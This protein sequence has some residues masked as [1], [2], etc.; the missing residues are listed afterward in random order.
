MN[1]LLLFV[2]FGGLAIATVVALMMIRMAMRQSH[3][4]H[5]E[6]EKAEIQGKLSLLE[7]EAAEARSQRAENAAMLEQKT[8]AI[9]E[10]QET[11]RRLEMALAERQQ[12][13]QQKDIAQAGEAKARQELA[14]MQQKLAESEKRMQDW[15]L[16]RTEA[17]SA[18][19]AS[20]LE[21]GGQLS[22]KLLEDHKRER[23]AAQKEAE[24]NAKKH[25]ETLLEQV[26]NLTKSV[27]TI[28][29][30][31][32]QT[33]EK[34]ATVWRALTTPAAAGSLAEVGL[35]NS[36]KNLGLEPV[37]DYMIQY[38]VAG[39]DQSRLRPDAVV[40]LPQDM[41]MVIDSK[42]SKFVLEIAETEVQGKDN[43]EALQKLSKTMNDHLKALVSKDYREAIRSTYRDS[44][45]IGELSVCLSVMYVPSESA[46]THIRNADPAFIERAEKNNIIV[47]SPASLHGLL[48]LARYNIGLQRQSENQEVLI[49]QV[50]GLIDSVITMLSYAE[51][52]GK[53]IKSAADNF[54]KFTRSANKNVF[55][56]MRKLTTLGIRP[57]KGKEL[58]KPL[59]GFEVRTQ[60]DLL[61]IE[62]EVETVQD[63]DTANL[64]DQKL[65]A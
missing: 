50:Q 55:S 7:K 22:S 49:S 64:L 48:S 25:A 19:K 18:A 45:R 30:Q 57:S 39:Q 9:T 38:S 26:N 27:A 24:T 1:N 33:Q 35:E 52:V 15:E 65:T 6:I 46:I 17:L 54:D 41:V 20:I 5:L 31:S 59:P 60:E 2:S 10:R 14:L 36:L 62:G 56:K 12:F 44:G 40:F 4:R 16:Q 63:A 13:L 51:N 37:R 29:S 61:L 53:G 3:S 32:T 23:E 8:I 58:P 21:A 42:A 11:E 47:A 34:M 43:A 28:G